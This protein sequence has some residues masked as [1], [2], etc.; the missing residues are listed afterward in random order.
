MS[1]NPFL[2]SYFNENIFNFSLFIFMLYMCL[3]Q[4]IFIILKSIY[5]IS[6]LSKTLSWGVLDFC[7][8]FFVSNKKIG[9]SVYLCGILCLLIY[10]C[11]NIASSLGWRQ[12]YHDAYTFFVHEFGLQLLYWFYINLFFFSFFSHV[13]KS[14]FFIL[15]SQHLV[16]SSFNPHSLLLYFFSEQGMPHIDID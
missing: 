2:I 7:K 15:F 3:L 13:G 10:L 16:T 9:I 8:G 14:F 11:W 12:H 1:E 5:L 4:F 6:S